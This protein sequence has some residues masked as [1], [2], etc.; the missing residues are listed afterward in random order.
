[1]WNSTNFTK[2]SRIARIAKKIV[3]DEGALHTVPLSSITIFFKNMKSK[4]I[5]THRELW[6]RDFP[7]GGEWDVGVTPLWYPVIERGRW[8]VRRDA[9]KFVVVFHSFYFRRDELL[10]VF[11][12]TEKGERKAKELA[13]QLCEQAWGWYS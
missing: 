8:T 9:D 10:G 7:V 1:M 13:R 6:G 5:K 3:I 2:L 11:E 12:P 4:R